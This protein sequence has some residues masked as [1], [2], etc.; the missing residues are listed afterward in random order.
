MKNISRQ[1]EREITS[2]DNKMATSIAAEL[3]DKINHI[4]YVEKVDALTTD[5][6]LP[7]SLFQIIKKTKKDTYTFS[8]DRFCNTRGVQKPDGMFELFTR[9]SGKTVSE[10]REDLVSYV[11]NNKECILQVATDY[12]KEKHMDVGM[13]CVIMRRACSPGDELALYLL[14]KLHNRHAVIYN[15]IKTWS[16]MDY[17]SIRPGAPLEDMCDITLV[18]RVNGFCEA[19]R[20]EKQQTK[21]PETSTSVATSSPGRI[22]ATPEKSTRKTTSISELLQTV[23]EKSKSNE[24]N[25]VSAKLS[26]D[27]ILPDGPR[28]RNTREPNPLR[29]R[30]SKH[31]VRDTRRNKNYSDNIDNNHLDPPLIKKKKLNVPSTLREP[32]RNRQL[33]QK[34]LTRRQLAQSAPPG[35]TRKLIGMYVQQ[36]DKKPKIEKVEKREDEFYQEEM[37]R[38]NRKKKPTDN[39]NWPKDAK[40]VHIDGSQCSEECMKTSRYHM[41]PEKIDDIPLTP[42]QSEDPR[43][44]RATIPI[45]KL[46]DTVTLTQDVSDTAIISNAVLN[47][48]CINSENNNDESVELH[49]AT[50][51]CTEDGL[52]NQPSQTNTN[53]ETAEGELCGATSDST[54]SDELHLNLQSNTIQYNINLS[55]T[56]ASAIPCDLP[57]IEK[58]TTPSEEEL[59]S[60]TPNR[61]YLI[62]DQTPESVTMINNLPLLEYNADLDDFETLMNIAN[63][64][65]NSELVPIDGPTQRDFSKEMDKDCGINQDLEIAMENAKFLDQHLLT[66]KSPEPRLPEQLD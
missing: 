7:E 65:E 14:C 33:A 17:K 59:P 27:N 2:A 1:K 34:I 52:V 62:E 12:F 57:Q 58:K 25:K 6:K 63:D 22:R 43:N 37:A 64:N 31:P 8:Y 40:L 20:I 5:H 47:L 24:I 38:I 16:T 19:T 44:T 41:E 3:L 9:Y 39:S 23:H 51:N 29:K 15:K 36:V 45:E 56:K 42:N 26:E 54:S 32:S 61:D 60:A 13:W 30:S 10:T 4:K 28:T 11:E 46:S 53:I 21:K 66:H 35:T 49:G 50:L 18:Y 48:D 55:T